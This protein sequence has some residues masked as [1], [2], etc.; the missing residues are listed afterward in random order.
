M[1]FRPLFS[2]KVLVSLIIA[3]A[4]LF[5]TAN[6]Q[7][8]SSQ[9][10]KDKQKIEKEISNTQSLLKSKSATVRNSSRR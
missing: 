1:K 3:I 2:Q 9:L 4:C 7:K 8:S 6:A 10:K 5:S